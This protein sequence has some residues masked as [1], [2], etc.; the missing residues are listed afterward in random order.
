SSFC[1]TP[2]WV[3]RAVTVTPGTTAPWASLTVP[4]MFPVTLARSREGAN[5]SNA[6]TS[7]HCFIREARDFPRSTSLLRLAD[8]LVAHWANF[9]GSNLRV[10]C[11]QH[12]CR[13]KHPCERTRNPNQR[14]FKLSSGLSLRKLVRNLYLRP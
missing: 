1:S 9:M 8:E 6:T 4:E 13:K 14:Q 7:M 2:V 10:R 3:F 5:A 12:V 11:P